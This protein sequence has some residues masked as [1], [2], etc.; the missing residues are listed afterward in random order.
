MFVHAIG[1]NE[2]CNY[3]ETLL[4]FM[5]LDKMLEILEFSPLLKF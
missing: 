4:I 2:K 3:G 1:V 5:V